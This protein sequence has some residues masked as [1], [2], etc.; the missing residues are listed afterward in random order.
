ME[1][2]L[3]DLVLRL[4]GSD[5]LQRPTPEQLRAVLAAL[6][7]AAAHYSQPGSGAAADAPPLPHFAVFGTKAPRAAG[8]NDSDANANAADPSAS[9]GSGPGARS[10]IADLVVVPLRGP[11]PAHPPPAS[12]HLTPVD[13]FS[14]KYWGISVSLAFVGMLLGAVAVAAIA[15]RRWVQC[16]WIRV[17]WGGCCAVGLPPGVAAVCCLVQPH[18]EQAAAAAAGELL[19]PWRR[20]LGG[21]WLPHRGARRRFGYCL[22]PCWPLPPTCAPPPPPTHAPW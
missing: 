5:P 16:A 14:P 13:S 12:T 6:A 19:A 4:V 20:W 11:A 2:L 1:Q 8:S 18:W 10:R 3:A 15:H 17:G 21:M 9:G 7:G 22:L